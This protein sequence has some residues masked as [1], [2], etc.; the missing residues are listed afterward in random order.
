MITFHSLPV[1]FRLC[2]TYFPYRTV[3]TRNYMKKCS[4]HLPTKDVPRKDN[5][6]PVPSVPIALQVPSGPVPFPF[7][8][9]ILPSVS[10]PVKHIF[11]FQ[12]ITVF[13]CKLP[14]FPINYHTFPLHKVLYLTV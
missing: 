13:A 9:R 7:C 5:F 10:R 6:F 3:H 4:P 2:I 14:D 12:Q 11:L 8:S 1:F